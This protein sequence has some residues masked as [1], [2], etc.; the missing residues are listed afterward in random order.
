[1]RRVA[2]IGA[3]AAGCFCAVEL[4]RRSPETSVTVYEAGPKALAKVAVTGGGRCNLSN[5]FLPERDLK[6]IYPRGT[7][8]MKRALRRFSPED[9]WNWFESEGVRLV[10]QEDQCV[11]PASQDAMQIVRTLLN[12]MS[13][14]GVRLRTGAPVSRI[15]RTGET[16][17]LELP[18]KREEADAVVVTTGGATQQSLRELLGTFGLKTET[19]VPSLFTFK[20]KDA[21]LNS[22]TGTTVQNVRLS[23]AGTPYRSEGILLITDWGVSGPATLKLSSY[24]ARHLAGVQYRSGLIINWLNATEEEAR[25]ALAALSCRAGSRQ[26]CN[27]RPP[28]LTDRLWR[29]ILN[30][31]GVRPDLRWA[32]L[33]GKGLNRLVSVLTADSYSIDGRAR[34]KEEFVTCGGVSL[35]SI[36][37]GT[38]ECKSVPGL[39][40][41]GEVLDIDAITGGFNLQAAWS[42]GFICAQT[43]CNF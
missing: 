5:S 16:F 41:A 19:P 25:A 18:D 29:H 27:A 2:I 35:E 28:E 30:R 3:G 37:I 33:G 8:L 32:E 26:V 11:F 9:T 23:L 42:T 21:E 17:V 20:V 10:L 31:A 14:S 12:L 6:F 22:L 4:K 7:T 13:A 24:A 15:T 43:L 1:M 38:L 40:F 39:L 36:N 34:F